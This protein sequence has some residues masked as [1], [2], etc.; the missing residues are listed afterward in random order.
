[1]NADA[2]RLILFT[3]ASNL[4]RSQM[5][6]SRCHRCPP[7]RTFSPKL[8]EFYD[9][10]KDELEVVFI[11]SDKDE[12]SFSGYFGKF[13]WLATVPA[14]SSTENSDR[15]QRLATMFKIQG[16]PSVIVLDAKTGHFI[17]DNAREEVMKASSEESKKALIASWLSK[18]AV[19]ID[20]AVLGGG[21]GG[22]SDNLLVKIFKYFLTRPTHIFGLI[23][24]I[25]QLLR[26][27][28]EQGKDG[29]EDQNEL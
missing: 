27:L 22:G 14:Y 3:T 15:Q 9:S 26:Y 18:E 13:P 21:G 25:K 24:F 17:T 1:M 7:C 29:I 28:E 6:L 4:K 11:S 2:L 5:K 20:Q 10:C 8:I 16:I 23:Y 19:P 12:K